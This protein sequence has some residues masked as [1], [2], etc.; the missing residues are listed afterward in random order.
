MFDKCN[1]KKKPGHQ[2]RIINM[3]DN[4][5]NQFIT[6]THMHVIAAVLECCLPVFYSIP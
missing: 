4:A 3:E 2:D 1:D 5:I 6:Y